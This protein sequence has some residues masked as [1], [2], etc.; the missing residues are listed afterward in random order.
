MEFE[1]DPDK[2]GGNWRKHAVS[3]EEASTVFG[4]WLGTTVPDPD[5]SI[6]ESRYLMVGRSNR[7]RLLIVSYAERS[8]GFRII[9]ARVLTRIER[10]AYEKE[11]T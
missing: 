10:K 9:S 3:F 4:D 6:A 1:W 2:A 7:N 11:S 5:N 8:G